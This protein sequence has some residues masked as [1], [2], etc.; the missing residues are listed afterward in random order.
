MLLFALDF[1]A[2]IDSMTAMC[3]FDLQK[4]ELS[5]AEWG[6]AKELRDILKVFFHSFCSFLFTKCFCQVFKD[7]TLF[8]LHGTPNLTT[9]IP[10]MD[11]IDKVLATS[12]DRHQYSLSICAALVIGKNTINWYYNKTDYS[13]TYHIAMGTHNLYS[14]IVI[15]FISS[16]SSP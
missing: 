5:P 3:D 7:A 10:A 15:V 14:H 16:S 2:A 12:S 6:I 8:F 1:C 11:H 13:E 4:Y 9:V